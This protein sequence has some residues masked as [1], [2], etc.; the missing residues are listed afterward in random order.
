MFIKNNTIKHL[1]GVLSWA[2]VFALASQAQ[3]GQPPKKNT[4]I[5]SKKN[6]STARCRFHLQGEDWVDSLRRSSHGGLCKTAM[7]IDGLFGNDKEFNDKNFRGKI[8]IGFK[9]DEVNGFDPRLRIRLRTKLPN[10]S[11]RLNA[12]VGRVEEEDFVSN[13]EIDKDSINAVGLRSSRRDNDQWLVGLGYRDPSSSKSGFDYSVGAKLSSGINPY[14]KVSYHNLFPVNKASFWRAKQTFFWRRDEKFG[15]SS[16]LDYTKILNEK[17]ILQWGA[18]LKYTQ[19]TEQI[20]WITSGTWHHSF[21]NE[22]GVSSRIYAR[23]EERDDELIPEYGVTFTY[24]QPFLRPWFFIETGIDFRWERFPNNRT[25]ENAT[26]FSLQF[27]M[28]LGDYY[29]E[30]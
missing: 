6:E 1:K 22:V 8:S 27:G 7:W 9:E 25:F 2:L 4:N 11:S 12:F 5:E 21:T 17:D 29:G 24:V 18:D 3:A 14:A 15:I 16:K 20:E 28:L 19:E 13:T 10:V 30:K 23:G 26:R